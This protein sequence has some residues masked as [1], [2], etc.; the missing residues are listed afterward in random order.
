LYTEQKFKGGIIWCY[1]EK[2]AVPHKQSS[3]L[4][5]IYNITKRARK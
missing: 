1:S 2:T 3:K 4:N 5:K